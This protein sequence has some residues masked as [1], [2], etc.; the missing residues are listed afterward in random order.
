MEIRA[1]IPVMN[2]VSLGIDYVEASTSC[3]GSVSL[4]IEGLKDVP[5]FEIE[6]DRA[7]LREFLLRTAPIVE[8]PIEHVA[9]NK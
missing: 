6:L 4:F 2:N 3:R 7:Q 9:P 8:S 1:K 5:K